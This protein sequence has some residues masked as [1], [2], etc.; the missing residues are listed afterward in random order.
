MK[1]VPIFDSG[2]DDQR[3]PVSLNKRP[4]S[5]QY[6]PIEKPLEIRVAMKNTMVTLRKKKSRPVR[7]GFFFKKLNVECWMLNEMLK[8][9]TTFNIYYLF[10]KACLRYFH[11]SNG[12]FKCYGL[13]IL[14]CFHAFAT[15]N[16]T[17]G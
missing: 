6:I 4:V 13:E 5:I 14:R 16:F 8:A 2:A 1:T 12:R 10:S 3:Y 11:R 15:G 17:A 9:F 7:R